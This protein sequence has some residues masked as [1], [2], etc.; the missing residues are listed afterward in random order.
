LQRKGQ[1]LDKDALN[2]KPFPPQFQKKNYY[3]IMDLEVE[4]HANIWREWVRAQG[5]LV[6]LV[7]ICFGSLIIETKTHVVINHHRSSNLYSLNQTMSTTR[8]CACTFTHKHTQN[9]PIGFDFIWSEKHP[10]GFDA[11]WRMK[12]PIG[13]YAIWRM[14]HP[15]WIWLHSF[16]V[17][18]IQLGFMSFE[19]W[20]TQLDFYF[21]WKWETSNWILRHLKCKT[22]QLDFISFWSEKH[23]IGDFTSFEV[24]NTQL[25][26]TSFKVGAWQSIYKHVEFRYT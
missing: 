5:I 1:A 19:V 4:G 15:N 26:L 13:F 21:V 14:K 24:L 25:H 17:R 3:L 11:I 2:P 8:K 7:I 20:N 6:I 23:T 16:E 18:N 10:I 22:S 12:H 9:T